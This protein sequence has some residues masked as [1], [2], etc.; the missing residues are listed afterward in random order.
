MFQNLGLQ[1]AV[2]ATT[3]RQQEGL[4]PGVQNSPSLTLTHSLRCVDAS[5]RLLTPLSTLGSKPREPVPH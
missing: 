5:R 4:V 3:A 2:C 1:E